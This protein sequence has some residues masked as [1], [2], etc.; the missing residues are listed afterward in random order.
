MALNGA[1]LTITFGTPDQPTRV[2]TAAAAAN[3][4]WNPRTSV[5]AGTGITD[6]VGNLGTSTGR[7][8]TDTDSDF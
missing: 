1:I 4:T 8:E 3:M 7:T 6:L 2:T 5:V